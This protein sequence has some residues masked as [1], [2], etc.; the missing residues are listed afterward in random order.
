MTL[1][2]EHG[3]QLK[4]L[5]AQLATLSASK[6]LQEVADKAQEAVVAATTDT[7]RR[8]DDAYE[9][10][11]RQNR[12]FGRNRPEQNPPARQR[13]FAMRF[14]PQWQNRDQE[15]RSGSAYAN[16]QR[17]SRCGTVHRRESF[18]LSEKPAESVPEG[19]ILRVNAGQS[20]E[21]AAND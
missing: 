5:S 9:T 16:R 13:G 2:E 10:T 19:T 7:R 12:T 6:S 18:L 21:M 17:C 8:N 20:R 4:Q 15:N 3:A 1:A 14:Q 11:T